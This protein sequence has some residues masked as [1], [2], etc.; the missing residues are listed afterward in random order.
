MVDIIIRAK[1]G[2]DLT[3]ACVAS[4][5]RNTP[6]DSYR[7]ILVDDGSD[8]PLDAP[9]DY[10]IRSAASQGAVSAT[11]L[12]LAVS[13]TKHDSAYV[14][15]MDN[16]TEIPEGDEGWLDRFVKE[17]EQYGPKTAAV[18]ATTNFAMAPQHILHT[19]KT[20]QA[21]WKDERA[22]TSGVKEN[23]PVIWFISFSVLL[24]KDVVR[25]VGPWDERFNPGNWEDTDYAVQLRTAGY[26]VRVARSVYIHHHGHRTFGAQLNDLLA[27]N[28]Q[29]FVDKW[30]PGRLFDLGLLTADTMDRLI[31]ATTGGNRG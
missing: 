6:K 31:K 11:N 16:D 25:Q 8:P 14:M 19:P 1:N 15:V 5:R 12:G 29:K 27:T 18:G 30:G 24:R 20:Y 3:A 7:I 21:D 28:E 2:H 22:K 4:I 10:L 17:L 13:L 9:V 26:D 23:P